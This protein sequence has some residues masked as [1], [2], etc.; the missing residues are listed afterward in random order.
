MGH[1]SLKVFSVL[2]KTEGLCGLECHYVLMGVKE[3][4]KHSSFAVYSSVIHPSPQ[5]STYLFRA[6]LFPYKKLH[7]SIFS[8]ISFE[9]LRKRNHTMHSFYG[10]LYC[11]GFSAL[12]KLLFLEVFYFSNFLTCSSENLVYLCVWLLTVHIS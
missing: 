10:I 7:I 12:Y 11:Y 9:F 4:H 8:H 5:H 6:H 2:T 1:S 3:I